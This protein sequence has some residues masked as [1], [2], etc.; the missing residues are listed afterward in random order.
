MCITIHVVMILVGVSWFWESETV[1]CRSTSSDIVQNLC[2]TGLTARVLFLAEQQNNPPKAH[3]LILQEVDSVMYRIPN[4]CTAIAD[5]LMCQG[6]I[7]TIDSRWECP[8]LPN[9]TIERNESELAG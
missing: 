3:R 2:G 8:N 7:K 5:L 4:S 6:V 9:V 1:N